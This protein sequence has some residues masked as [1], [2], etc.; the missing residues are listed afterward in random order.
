MTDRR[1]TRSPN[2]P[3]AQY[4]DWALSKLAGG[5][6]LPASRS[7]VVR[8]YD[9]KTPICAGCREA[10][11]RYRL[12]RKTASTS[13]SETARPAIRESDAPNVASGITLGRDADGRCAPVLP[14]T[15]AEKIDALAELQA[16]W[17]E[18]RP[19]VLAPF[20]PAPILKESR[21]ILAQITSLQ[22]DLSAGAQIAAESGVSSFDELA[23][24]R[25]SLSTR[26]RPG[27]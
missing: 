8:H 25:Q 22:S 14:Q 18:L 3:T 17:T 9:N 1:L 6:E 2:A 24:R 4:C 7:G 16:I 15:T 13:T 23:A 10:A 27:E 21:M 26:K 11:R 5:A 20:A 19:R 12:A